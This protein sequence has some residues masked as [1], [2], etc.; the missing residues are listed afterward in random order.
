M[1][2]AGLADR[3]VFFLLPCVAAL[4]FASLVPAI[5]AVVISL[6]DYNWGNRFDFVGLANYAELLGGKEFWVIVGNTVVFA[7]SACTVEVALG[8]YLATQVDRLPI[9]GNVVRALL[10]T[11][12]MVSGIIVALMSK[13]MF[14]PFL[15]VIN[16]LMSLFGAGPSAFYGSPETAMASVVAV[17]VWWQTAF[18]FIIMLAGL[19]NIPREPLEAARV[20][21]ASE[22]QIFWR[23]KF[24]LLLP[25]LLTVVVF[26]SIDT[27]KVFDIVFGTTGGG[28][29]LSTEVMQTLAYRTSYGY[30]QI[31]KSMAIMVLFSVSILAL[32][33]AYS[34]LQ[35]D[36]ER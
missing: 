34:R 7:L 1:R 36:A 25:L 17:D 19:Q 33:F 16:H 32:C 12:L 9:Q 24:P 23:I 14:D 31:G 5:A 20:E 8:L 29:A 3:P 13:V 10:M 22:T 21:G 2:V 6:H 18:V 4:A 26:R 30:L 28:P 11:P 27:L 15:G 35:P